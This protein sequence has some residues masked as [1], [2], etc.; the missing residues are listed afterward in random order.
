MHPYRP[1]F[2]LSAIRQFGHFSGWMLVR[3]IATGLS[4]HLVN[5]LI[6]R[7]I[8]VA[9]LAFFSAAREMAEMATTELQAPIR[10]AMFP[11]F[12]AVNHDPAL[13]RRSYVDWTAVMVLLT[14]P[15]RIGLALVAPDAVRVLLGE[16]WLPVV[17]LLQILACAGIFRASVAGAQLMLIAMGKPRPAAIVAVLRAVVLIPLVVVGIAL[18]DATGAAVAMFAMAGMMFVVN[19]AVVVRTVHVSRGELLEASWRPIV[20]TLVMAGAVL[21]LAPLL[22]GDAS[23]SAAFVPPCRRVARR[24]GFIRAGAVVAVVARGAACGRRSARTEF[25]AAGARLARR[26]LGSLGRAARFS[27]GDAISPA[28]SDQS[29]ASRPPRARGPLGGSRRRARARDDAAPARAHARLELHVVHDHAADTK[30]CAGPDRGVTRDRRAGRQPCTR[31]DVDAVAD[32]HQA[33]DLGVGAD[34]RMRQHPAANARL[35]THVD[36]IADP[37]AGKVRKE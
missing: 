24:P 22:P 15:F 20:A 19:L 11:G 33:A 26:A 17:A 21:A 35:R 36:A 5:L 7:S 10:R 16:R 13:L 1:R 37:H 14:F 9:G 2:T 25:C 18:A 30:E 28:A 8:S 12:A 31:A 4:D 32:V 6:G 3:N 29:A 27:R 34:R 23:L